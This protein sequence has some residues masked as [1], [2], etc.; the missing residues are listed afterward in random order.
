MFI[1]ST[2]GNKITVN[3][4][5]II[6][7]NIKKKHYINKYNAEL[8]K[9]G[10]GKNLLINN[11]PTDLF[12]I[13]IF[14]KRAIFING[15]LKYPNKSIPIRSPIA[16]KKILSNYLIQNQ[17]NP[18]K[19]VPINNVIIPESTNNSIRKPNKNIILIEILKNQP[20]DNIIKIITIN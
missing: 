8:I 19:N 18:N 12:I 14:L 1:I 15:I 20:M 16:K 6:L 9:K 17:V 2:I 10:V 7:K 3:Y 4:T 5:P 13:K 11:N